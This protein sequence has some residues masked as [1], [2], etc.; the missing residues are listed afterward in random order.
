MDNFHSIPPPP[1]RRPSKRKFYV[2]C[3]FGVSD[4]MCSCAGA[5]LQP[6]PAAEP[7]DDHPVQQDKKKRSSLRP[8]GLMPLAAQGEIPPYRAIPFRDHIAEGALHAFR[9]EKTVPVLRVS[10]W[11]GVLRDYL[12]RRRWVL[13]FLGNKRKR[14]LLRSLFSDPLPEGHP[15]D[16][17]SFFCLCIM[18]C[19]QMASRYCMAEMSLLSGR[20]RTSRA[21]ARAGGIAPSL[22]MLR[23]S[24]RNCFKH[25]QY[26]SLPSRLLPNSCLLN[27]GRCPNRT[28]LRGSF[29]VFLSKGKATKFV[30]TRGFSKRTRFR[31]TENLVE[32]LILSTWTWLEHF[33][34]KPLS[35]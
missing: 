30:R 6:P 33:R 9:T 17:D 15:V 10:F 5:T 7:A 18:P 34:S 13:K 31:N 35:F 24:S 4:M 21:H 28:E 12:L 3:R 29:L 20:Y 22:A 2:Y 27:P 8:S 23:H 32:P 14:Q 16:R 11:K 1:F 26:N 25:V 19:F